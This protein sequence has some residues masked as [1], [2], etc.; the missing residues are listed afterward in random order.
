MSLALSPAA[1][2]RSGRRRV[3]IRQPIGRSLERRRPSVGDRLRPSSVRQRSEGG[4]ESLFRQSGLPQALGQTLQRGIP[5]VDATDGALRDDATALCL[6]WHGG[7]ERE[8]TSRA[9]ANA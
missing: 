5:V 3:R 7:P 9:G 2:C 4:Q 8:R 6:D 1:V